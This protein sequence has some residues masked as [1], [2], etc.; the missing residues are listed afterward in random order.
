VFKQSDQ[1]LDQLRLGISILL[2]HALFLLIKKLHHN[3]KTALVL[4]DTE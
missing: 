3:Y 4:V 2:T 1:D